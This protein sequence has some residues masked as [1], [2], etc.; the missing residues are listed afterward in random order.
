[1]EFAHITFPIMLM[2]VI[3]SLFS[4]VLFQL[5]K[6]T[7]H[8]HKAINNITDRYTTVKGGIFLFSPSS[9]NPEGQIHLIKA[10]KHFRNLLLSMTPVFVF[11]V[12]VV[13]IKVYAN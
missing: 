11:M 12:V 6:I 10:K 13:L 7:Y 3:I 8:L 9:F 1:M 2:I 5:A 4:Y